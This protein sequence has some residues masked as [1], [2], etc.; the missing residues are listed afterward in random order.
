FWLNPLAAIFTVGFSVVFLILLGASAGNSTSKVLG[1]S[2]VI[3]YYVP[4]FVSYG[5]MSTCFNA[6]ATSLVVR[7]EMGLLKRLR[8]SP[9]P[10]WAMISAVCANAV[11]ISFV[12]VVVL[13]LIGRLGYGVHLPR[14]YAALIIA[15]LVGAVC[16]TALGIAVSTLIPNQEAAGPVVSI[17]FFVLL[18]LSGL[19]YPIDPHS[20]LARAASYFPIRHMITAVY[21]PFDL[22]KNISGWSWGDLGALAIWGVVAVVVA[23]RRWSWAP[24]RASGRGPR[25]AG[26]AV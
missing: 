16:F 11:I 20:G 6:L 12:Q 1:G 25:L 7:R 5:V 4:G 18:F 8:L 3:Q 10:A 13:L 9:L 17:V 23:L 19:W 26:R 22:R 15:L 2:R 24:R 21:A 14:N